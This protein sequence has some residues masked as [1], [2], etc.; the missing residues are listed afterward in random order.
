MFTSLEQERQF[1]KDVLKAGRKRIAKMEREAKA[2]R[3]AYDKR[4]TQLVKE[5]VAMIKR[6]W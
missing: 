5:G 1:D 6:Y 2:T 4:M 3:K